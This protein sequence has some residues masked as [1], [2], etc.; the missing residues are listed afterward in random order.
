MDNIS[1][2][3]E[4]QQPKPKIVQ[5]GQKFHPFDPA[6]NGTDITEG[7]HTLS[8]PDEDLKIPL[9]IGI[10]PSRVSARVAIDPFNP[11]IGYRID[12]EDLNLE[13][14]IAKNRRLMHKPEFAIRYSKTPVVL[15]IQVMRDVLAKA[16]IKKESRML[17]DKLSEETLGLLRKLR[18][19][20]VSGQ[21]SFEAKPNETSLSLGELELNYFYP[22]DSGPL[23]TTEDLANNEGLYEGFLL[24][25]PND[26]EKLKQIQVQLVLAEE[27]PKK[28]K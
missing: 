26:L 11:E 9:D 24:I 1:E 20:V 2:Q 5:L 7:T 13:S 23:P 22:V 16:L 25:F 3:K 6:E 19:R 12:N 15:R 10:D 18:A 14:R 21:T 28:V 17:T 27:E 4:Q 8:I